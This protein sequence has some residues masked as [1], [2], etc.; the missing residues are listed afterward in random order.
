MQHS[1][2][3]NQSQPAEG[4]QSLLRAAEKLFAQKGYA[5]TSLRDIAAEANVSL[6]LIR[7]HFGA[8]EDL[9]AAVDAEVLTRIKGLYSLV[10]EHSATKSLERVVDDAM[11]WILADPGAL[12]YARMSLMEKTSGSEKLFAELLQTMRHFIDQYDEKGFLQD[13]VDKEWAAIYMVFDFIGPAIIE[14]F[15]MEQFGASMYSKKMIKR[16]NS[17]MRTL[18]TRGVLK[19]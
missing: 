13:D 7:I 19:P 11:T 14:P 5:G 2:E 15:A 4:R 8:K 1:T 9:Q 10:V 18:F 6:G 3:K 12:M 16:R 17:F